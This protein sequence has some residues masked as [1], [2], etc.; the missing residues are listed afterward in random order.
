MKKT[1]TQATRF[2]DA[3]ETGF[4]AAASSEI[5]AI[6]MEFLA[7]RGM[8]KSINRRILAAATK[9]Q[10]KE[11]GTASFRFGTF[12]DW[13]GRLYFHGAGLAPQ[14]K[15]MGRGC[16]Q[17]AEAAVLGVSGVRHLMAGV[18]TTWGQ[19]GMDKASIRNR[20]RGVRLMLKDGSLRQIVQGAQDGTNFMWRLADEP[21]QFLALA[22]D[23]LAAVDSGSPATYASACF[24]GYDATCSGLQILA[25]VTGCQ[26]TAL[27]VNV[28]PRA[29]G[30]RADVYLA[31]AKGLAD[32]CAAL[33]AGMD[34]AEAEKAMAANESGDHWALFW[35]RAGI[36]RTITKTPVMVYCYGGTKRTFCASIHEDAKAFKASWKACMWL[37]STMYDD[38]LADLL[39]KAHAF[40]KATQELARVLAKHGKAI[41]FTAADGL[42]FRQAVMETEKG[43]VSCPLADG[44]RI[45]AVVQT[46]TNKLC[47]AKQAS[48]VAP[49][50]VHH[51]DGLFLRNVVRALHAA[52]IKHFF[53]VHDCFYLRA[54]DWAQGWKIIRAVFVETFSADVAAQVWQDIADAANGFA[55]DPQADAWES[56][57]GAVCDQPERTVILP[58]C[59]VRGG[60]DLTQALRSEFLFS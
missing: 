19:N 46:R 60:L 20:V 38:V 30:N 12:L 52:G 47:S 23:L 7:E 14:G 56:E 59:P 21:V 22:I 45:Q 13:R 55:R 36:T 27:M 31:V 26:D 44:R 10:I 18:G 1:P 41:A 58:A 28:A 50:L 42:P 54:A 6:G 32:R 8:Q 48:G 39:P 16:L 9:R 33:V 40:M 25:A 15:D 51:W 11:A 43:R 53:T 2:G 5:D 3:D 37:A 49:N 34:E 57:G 24:I 4:L 17:A 35:H 29:D